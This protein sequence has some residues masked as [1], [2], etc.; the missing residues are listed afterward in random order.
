MTGSEAKTEPGFSALVLAAD[1]T[2]EDAVARFARVACKAAAPVG[3]VPLLLRVLN[4]LEQV[5][6]MQRALVV[7][8]SAASLAVSPQLVTGLRRDR[9]ARIEPAPSPSRSA[10]AGLLAL[11]ADYPILITTADHALLTASL[12]GEFVTASRKTGA[13]LAVGLV[14]YARVRAAFPGVRRTVLRFRDAEYC[15]CNLFTVLSASGSR[16]I[17]FWVRVE[18]QR[19]HPARLVAGIL[20]VGGVV[21]YL[22]GTLTLADALSR[23]SLRLG[24]RI[25]P[26]ILDDPEASVDVDTPD[27][28]RRVEAILARRQGAPVPA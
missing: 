23:A 8:P 14:P 2:P 21:R 18:R 5:P 7:G 26:V 16:V 3:G 11:G 20:G 9:V 12:V 1:R 19:K 27:D 22:L 24:A 17:D 13:D 10:A 4:A 15:T 25:T 28:L 6:G